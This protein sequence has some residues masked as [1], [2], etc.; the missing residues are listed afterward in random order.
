MDKANRTEPQPPNQINEAELT[1]DTELNEAELD[2]VNGG[3]KQNNHSS[4]SFLYA[5]AQ[6]L[7]QAADKQAQK[8]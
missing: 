6:A 4:H 5:V 7:G 3:T 2:A 1:D 8:L